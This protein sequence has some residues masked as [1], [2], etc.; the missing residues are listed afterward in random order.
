MPGFIPG[1]ERPDS[2][3]AEVVVRN[4]RIW[5]G[6]SYQPWANA[7]AII[8][9]TIAAVGS[10][11]DIQSWISEDTQIISADGGMV[12]P[13][14]IDSHI[15]LEELGTVLTSVQLRDAKSKE[16]FVQRIKIIPLH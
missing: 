13:G 5:T 1:F 11:Q 10:I 8:E 14:F 9:D 15:H 3:Y 12:V 4:G 16:E 7:M 6:D 2:V